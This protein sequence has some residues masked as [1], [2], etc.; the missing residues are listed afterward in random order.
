M[1]RTEWEAVLT[2]PVDEQRDHVQGTASAA[3]TLVQYGDYECP[4]CG[5]AYPII[6]DVH[7]IAFLVH[8]LGEDGLPLGPAHVASPLPFSSSSARR[9]PSAPGFTPTG[10]T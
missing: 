4:Y 8:R 9:M 2:L 1:S 10:E 7:V 6:K 5:E 3:V